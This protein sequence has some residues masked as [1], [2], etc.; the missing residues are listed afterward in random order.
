MAATCRSFVIY[1]FSYIEQTAVRHMGITLTNIKWSGGAC[2]VCDV[3]GF[4][5]EVNVN[6]DIDHFPPGTRTLAMRISISGS[7]GPV[8]EC[9]PA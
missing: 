7:N 4:I 2:N 8:S 1:Y 3:G 6:T 5:S 9:T